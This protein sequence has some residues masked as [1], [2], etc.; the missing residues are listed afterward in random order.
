M[1]DKNYFFLKSYFLRLLIKKKKKIRVKLD[2]LL[3]VRMTSI[4]LLNY[5]KLFFIFIFIIIR[6]LF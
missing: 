5:Y 2:L 3:N 1:P 6:Y 4:I